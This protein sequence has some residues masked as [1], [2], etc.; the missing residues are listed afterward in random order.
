MPFFGNFQPRVLLDL[1]G[2]QS[3]VG[4]VQAGKSVG[5]NVNQLG[6]VEPSRHPPQ[7]AR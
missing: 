7:S 3:D 4:G 1:A 6:G 2:L 5:L